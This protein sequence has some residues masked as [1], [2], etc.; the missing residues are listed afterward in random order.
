MGG[1]DKGRR[2]QGDTH[3]YM[4]QSTETTRPLKDFELKSVRCL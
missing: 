1:V 3:V 2:L 4:V